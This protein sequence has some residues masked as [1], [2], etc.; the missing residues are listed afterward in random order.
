MVVTPRAPWARGDPASPGRASGASD[1]TRSRYQSC[2]EE[3]Q[4]SP[5]SEVPLFEQA[6]P[7]KTYSGRQDIRLFFRE[8]VASRVNDSIWK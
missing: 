3:Q 1:Q 8:C 2:K 7:I 6:S 4:L 5:E